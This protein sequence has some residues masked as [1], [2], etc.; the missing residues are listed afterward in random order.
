MAA[1]CLNSHAPKLC[2]ATS[3]QER[4][5]T[6]TTCATLSL[7]LPYTTQTCND[8]FFNTLAVRVLILRPHSCSRTIPTR[9]SWDMDD[10]IQESHYGASMSCAAIPRSI[11]FLTLFSRVSTIPSQTVSPS[12]N[13]QASPTLSHRMATTKKPTTAPSPT[14]T[15][16]LV[17]Y[18]PI[19]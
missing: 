17:L 7:S 11:R 18:P 16:P 15:S 14:V 5:T 1:A 10:E 13:S 8:D 4:P 12:L 6:S 2:C 19:H 9:A 3:F